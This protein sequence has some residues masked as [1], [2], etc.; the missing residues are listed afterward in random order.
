MINMNP[1]DIQSMVDDFKMKLSD[2]EYKDISDALMKMSQKPNG[3]VV[4]REFIHIRR[5]EEEEEYLEFIKNLGRIAKI[6]LII[7]IGSLIKITLEAF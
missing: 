5:N 1:I 4:V 3:V 2:K 6:A 7:F